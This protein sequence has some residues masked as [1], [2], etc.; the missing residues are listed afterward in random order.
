MKKYAAP[1]YA[2]T[3]AGAEIVRRVRAS[4]KITRISPSVAIAAASKCTGLARW[5]NEIL[6]AAL[7]NLPFAVTAPR[8]Q[9]IT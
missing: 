3:A 8:M 9:P 2:P 6:V 4:A 5:W 1:T 7:A